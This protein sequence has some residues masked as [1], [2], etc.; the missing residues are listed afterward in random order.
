MSRIEF[1][2]NDTSG[3][4]DTESGEYDYDGDSN[5]LRYFFANLDEY[6]TV[7]TEPMWGIEEHPAET[8]TA[9]SPE[10][11]REKVLNYLSKID[12]VEIHE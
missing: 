8:W 2:H 9:L 6:E 5:L 10:G 12:G 11:K 4:V 1:T 3:W 7:K